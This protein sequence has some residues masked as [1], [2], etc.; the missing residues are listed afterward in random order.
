MEYTEYTCNAFVDMLASASPTPG[1]GGTAA[2]VG[3]LGMALGNMVGSLTLGKKKYA[4]VE[5]DV[6]A[7]MTNGSH[8]IHELME[9]VQ[10]DADVFTPLAK[11][12]GMPAD[13]EEQAAEKAAVLERATLDACSV[14]MQIMEKSCRA[15]ELMVEYAAKGSRLAISDAGCGAACCK[16]ALLAASLNVFINTKTMQDRA[17]ADA[18]NAQAD[19]M[20]AKYAPMADAIYESVRKGLGREG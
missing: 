11:A 19:A 6:R 16:A 3:A 18:L 12:Y 17:K 2:L 1:G 5:A 9:L 15:I 10:R 7:L 14:P 13:T 4:G 8:L 20:I